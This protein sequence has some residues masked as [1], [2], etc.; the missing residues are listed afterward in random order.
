MSNRYQKN[1]GTN[2]R[3]VPI[4]ISAAI[5]ASI[6]PVVVWPFYM[7]RH[8]LSNN[9]TTWVLATLFPI[10]IILSG[11]LAYKCYPLRKEITYMLLTLMWLSYA[12][13]FLL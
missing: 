9:D 8:D 11:F 12:A 2:S 6:L 4:G 3:K 10:Y 13:I 1:K 5:T 7:M